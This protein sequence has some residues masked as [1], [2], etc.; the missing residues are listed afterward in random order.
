MDLFHVWFK[1]YSAMGDRALEMY[2]LCP[3]DVCIKCVDTVQQ[4]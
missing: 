1:H 4:L 3:L 2:Y